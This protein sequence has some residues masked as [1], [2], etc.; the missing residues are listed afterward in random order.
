MDLK[1]IFA[2]CFFISLICF[3]GGMLF[4]PKTYL[5][6]IAMHVG[7]FS[8]SLYFLYDGDLTNTFKRIGI[9]GNIKKNIIYTGL[10]FIA[11]MALII[12]INLIG[13]ATGINDAEKVY[14]RAQQL[15]TYLLILAVLFVPFSE[16]LFFRAFLTPKI[17]MILSSVLFALSHFAYGSI[18]EIIGTFVIGIV[19]AYL[20]KS[21]KSIVPPITLHLVYNLLSVMLLRGIV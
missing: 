15:P 19:F 12:P 14:E 3:I 4:I 10:G 1:K 17:G 13:T 18:M 21:S 11:I 20:Y 5:H 2:V 16:E 6:V 9:P 7:L 8:V